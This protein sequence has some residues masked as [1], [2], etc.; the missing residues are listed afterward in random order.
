MESGEACPEEAREEIRARGARVYAGG[1]EQETGEGRA[2]VRD[3]ER[4]EDRGHRREKSEQHSEGTTT[5]RAAAR[6]TTR[7]S[8]SGRRGSGGRGGGKKQHSG[9]AA[10]SPRKGNG[11]TAVRGKEQAA[12]EGHPTAPRDSALGSSGGTQQPRSHSPARAPLK[13]S[14][15]TAARD[16]GLDPERACAKRPRAGDK[17]PG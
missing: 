16:S 13:A 3:R 7:W 11:S 15:S 10:G 2:Y 12:P 5:V 4:G 6:V 1:T 14:L 17:G 9:G 8:A